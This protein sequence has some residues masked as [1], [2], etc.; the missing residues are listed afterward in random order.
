[1]PTRI[2]EDRIHSL[3]L[4]QLRQILG[5]RNEDHQEW[6]AQG[7][8]TNGAHVYAVTRVPDQLVVFDQL[9]PPGELP[10]RPHLVAEEGL[11]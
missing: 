10:V 9:V 5:R 4:V 6:I 7:A 2:L 1:M 8:L 11:W 3:D